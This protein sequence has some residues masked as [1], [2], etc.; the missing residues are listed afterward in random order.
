MK[1]AFYIKKPCEELWNN[2][3]E[4]SDGKFCSFCQKKVYDLDKIPSLEFDNFTKNNT[5]ICGK[6]TSIKP[7][8]SGLFLA[9]TLTS[10]T[11]LHAQSSNK[12]VTENT[13]QKEITINGKLTTSENRK[14]ISGEI[15]LVTLEKIYSAKADGSGNFSL[16][17]PEKILSEYNILRIDYAIS[18]DGTEFNDSKTSIFKID[19]LL[20]KQNFE[21][22]E[23]YITI[24]DVIFLAHPPPDY[25]YFDGKI[26]NKRK[27]K[28]LKQKNSNYKYM[29][30]HDDVVVKKLTG[31]SFVN[32]L[33]LLYSN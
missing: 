27:F 28:K 13:Y 26:T 17:F 3:K 19:E 23:Q 25:Y 20:G 12:S 30:F 9:L 21:V 32:N 22:E 15:F 29:K 14:L 31:K 7:V 8:L 11:Y 1:K 24:G 16:K 5:Q 6:K 4:I 33:Y 18:E 2:M 10:S